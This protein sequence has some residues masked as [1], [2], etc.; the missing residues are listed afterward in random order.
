ME[1]G[2]WRLGIEEFDALY[3]LW[4][5]GVAPVGIEDVRDYASKFAEE[6]DAVA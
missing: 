3:I 4:A 2:Q 6:Y 1:V 5:D